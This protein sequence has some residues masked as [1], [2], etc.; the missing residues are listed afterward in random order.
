MVGNIVRKVQF[1]RYGPQVFWV[2][3]TFKLTKFSICL[4]NF[5]PVNQSHYNDRDKE[6]ALEHELF[7]FLVERVTHMVHNETFKLQKYR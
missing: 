6:Y 3:T 2:S 1:L 5:Y 7:N 4:K